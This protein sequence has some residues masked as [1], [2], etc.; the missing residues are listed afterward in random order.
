MW[1]LWPFLSLSI[2][3]LVFVHVVACIST[4]FL[5]VV[6]QYSVAWYSTARLFIH[7]WVDIWVFPFFGY[8]GHRIQFLWG[9]M[10]SVLLGVYVLGVERLGQV[11]TWYLTFWRCHW[12]FEASVKENLHRPQQIFSIVI[13]R[14][15][16]IVVALTRCDLYQHHVFLLPT[17]SVLYIP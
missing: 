10:F 6:E 2:M 11:V 12:S 9:H 14:I 16:K 13:E 15:P 17:V 7:Q 8:W 1:T 5:F 4:L 3:F